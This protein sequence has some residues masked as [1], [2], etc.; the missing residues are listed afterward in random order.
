MITYDETDGLYDHT[1]PKVRSFDALGNPLDQGPR[2]PMIVLS[3]YGVVHAISHERTEHSSIIKF[4]DELF[5]LTPLANLPD[6]AAAR[7]LGQKE[8][9]QPNLGPADAK[10][11]GVG[12]L[13]SA[14]DNARLAGKADPL[15]AAYAMIPK[16]L[17]TALPHFAGNGCRVLQISPSDATLPNPIPADFNPRPDIN[18]GIPTSGTWTY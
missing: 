14:F 11:P 10:V 15:P 2:I 4:I 8:L 9:G 1:Q 6:E 12:D 3:P 5:N 7:K 13:F 16:P 17:V 18:P